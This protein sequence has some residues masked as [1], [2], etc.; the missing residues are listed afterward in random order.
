MKQLTILF[1]SLCFTI[2]ALCQK[3]KIQ[4]G[5]EFKLRKG[6]TDLD[7]VYSDNSGV[8]LQESHLALKS[9]FVIGASFRSSSALVKLDKNLSEIYRNDFNKELKGK[10]FDQFFM[11]Q[12][13]MLVFAYEYN[14][15]EKLLTLSAAEV[16]KATGRLSSDWQELA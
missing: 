9:Y 3:P 8:Y 2:P 15:R 11:L 4:W 10:E 13:K 1:L 16:D 7:V 12:N 6:S 5:D 14:K